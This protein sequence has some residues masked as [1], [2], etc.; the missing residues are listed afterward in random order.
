MFK[1]RGYENLD[2][3]GMS[4]G[5]VAAVATG[6]ILLVVAASLTITFGVLWGNAIQCD[7]P[8]E[9]FPSAKYPLAAPITANSRTALVTGVSRGNGR[10][11]AQKLTSLGWRVIGTSRNFPTASFS[12]PSFKP[13]SDPG[14]AHQMYLDLAN[15]TGFPTFL[16]ELNGYLTSIGSPELDLIVLSAAVFWFGDQKGTHDKQLG[17]G[18][19]YG[20][21]GILPS[22]AGDNYALPCFP[23]TKPE[24]SAPHVYFATG[25][26]PVDRYDRAALITGTNN[27]KL[28]KTLLFDLPVVSQTAR[29]VT[30]TSA[31]SFVRSNIGSRP[32]TAGKKTLRDAI[33]VLRA[34]ILTL[35]PT[36]LTQISFTQVHPTIINTD[37]FG[38][39]YQNPTVGAVYGNIETTPY[40]AIAA[41]EKNAIMSAPSVVGETVAQVAQMTSPPPTD[42]LTGLSTPLGREAWI[43]FLTYEW[44]GG[45][46]FNGL[47]MKEF[48]QAGFAN[49]VVAESI[50]AIAGTKPVVSLLE[51]VNYEDL[52]ATAPLELPP[53]TGANVRKKRFLFSSPNIRS[54]TM[55]F[56]I[57]LNGGSFV[58][59]PTTRIAANPAIG[60]LVD[61]WQSNA[62]M[63]FTTLAGTTVN[64]TIRGRD[65]SRTPYTHMVDASSEY[66]LRL[67]IPA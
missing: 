25:D 51:P 2:G 42:V 58:T 1:R 35:R 5:A 3:S 47:A 59:V 14:V 31:L 11:I 9:V 29:V 41:V 23:Y 19:V 61:I 7:I 8:M 30:I 16:G 32:Y 24:C 10:A 52:G 28:L 4:A 49:G 17:Q 45:P 54:T 56:S 34:E 21:S 22:L 40:T 13:A 53:R 66:S 43:R 48:T 39:Y 60:Q 37:G 63:D 36:N 50:L 15:T 27:L 44:C 67:T 33:D 65:T 64:V 18:P 55:S 26:T 57:S 46:G 12:F 6:V 38:I 20:P 62:L